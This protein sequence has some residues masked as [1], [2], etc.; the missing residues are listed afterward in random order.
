ML[1]AGGSSGRPP[2]LPALPAGLEEQAFAR[3][4]FSPNHRGASSVVVRLSRCGISC[5]SSFLRP[6]HSRTHSGGKEGGTSYQSC[7]CGYLQL[8]VVSRGGNVLH[9]PLQFLPNALVPALHSWYATEYP[10]LHV[11]LAALQVPRDVSRHAGGETESTPPRPAPNQRRQTGATTGPPS[12][13][14]EPLTL[15][16]RKLASRKGGAGSLAVYKAEARREKKQDGNLETGR[17]LFS[18]PWAC[19][20]TAL[21]TSST[22][23]WME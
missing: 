23:R 21:L 17:F 8:D 9:P 18:G 13:S 11:Q 19:Y 2:A 22:C 6:T 5:A 10:T 4:F 7:R 20:E 12:P 15:N 14:N 16:C 1:S 3:P